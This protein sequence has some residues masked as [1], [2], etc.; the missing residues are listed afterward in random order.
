[1]STAAVTSNSMATPPKNP[2]VHITRF[3]RAP[4][5]HVFAAW[6]DPEQMKRWMGPVNSTC[7]EAETDLRV[8]GSYRFVVLGTLP[9]T[10]GEPPQERTHIVTGEYLEVVPPEL[11]RYTWRGNLVPDSKSIVTLRLHEESG[12]TRLE[13][14]HENLSSIDAASG[15]NAGW[16]SVLDKLATYIE[17]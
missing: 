1:M 4:R 15:Y 5:E 14:L 12:G 3:I 2:Q 11:V 7:T 8:G 6:T 16:N 17:R 10:N 13:L 9:S